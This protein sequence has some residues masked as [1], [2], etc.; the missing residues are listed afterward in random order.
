MLEQ[1]EVLKH[2]ADVQALLGRGFFGDLVELAIFFLV[3]DELAIHLD[4]SR[5]HFFQV[6][7]AA[8]QRGFT[9]A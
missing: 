6:I 8:Q 1:I 5:V 4:S 7:H 9:G 3:A 2:H